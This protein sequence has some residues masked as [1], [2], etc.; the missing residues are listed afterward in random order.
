MR[1]VTLAGVSLGMLVVSGF[2]GAIAPDMQH[3]SVDLEARALG[4]DDK[5][6]RIL[7]KRRRR[8]NTKRNLATRN[9]IKRNLAKR[10]TSTS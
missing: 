2:V 7:E 3:N 1:T 10:H 4:P 6:F 9:I 8:R 5:L